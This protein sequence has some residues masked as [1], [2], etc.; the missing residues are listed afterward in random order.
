MASRKQASC[1]GIGMEFEKAVK[2]VL[3]KGEK[4]GAEQIEVCAL[5]GK[6]TFLFVEKNRVNT[7]A[8]V[9]SG[10][11]VRAVANKNW[12]FSY[13]LDFS[14]DALDQT[15]KSAISAAKAK[16]EDKYFESLPE[17]MKAE[18]L[19]KKIDERIIDYTP[20]QMIE[21][22]DRVK[23]VLDEKK[24][25]VFFGMTA[26]MYFNSIIANSLGLEHYDDVAGFG[27][28]FY[29]GYV[30]EIP[31]ALGFAYKFV[32]NLDEI[33]PEEL[34]REV[35]KEVER[36]KGSKSIKYE[37]KTTIIL[38]P[39]AVSNLMW[40]FVKEILADSVDRGATP[41]TRDRIGEKVASNILSI[42]DNVRS[43][44]NPFASERDWEGVPT[45]RT[46]VIE[47]GELKSFLVDYYY[48]R[49]WRIEPTG[50]AVK[51]G[52]GPLDYISRPPSPGSFFLE[53]RGERE[54]PLDSIIADVKEGF[55]VREVMG[56][57][58]SDFSSGKFSVPAFGWYIKGG[59]VKYPVRNLMF[60]GTMPQLLKNTYAVSKEKKVEAGII[61]EFPYIA[62]RDILVSASPP[63]L[64]EKLG[65]S[66]LNLLIKLGVVKSPLA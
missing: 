35:V 9:I 62:V 64:K 52:Q 16:G 30:R 18:P 60:S 50:N 55:L 2:Y 15:I 56:V 5:R 31:P 33:I 12:G 48:A 41:F 51:G 37:G 53:V 20:A 40:I 19:E 44:K 58:M 34:G 27:S 13:T 22:Y 4:L 24:I 23:R 42:Y 39:T 6:V 45:R 46:A 66:I 8:E 21:F 3:E 29:A 59:E 43:P 63:A 49:K 32:A 47:K 10:I 25:T 54:E 17:P 7:A 36:A 1:R 14:E 26:S 57:H 61:G 38:E 28:M 65:L 11:S